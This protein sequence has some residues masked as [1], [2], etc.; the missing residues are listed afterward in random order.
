MKLTVLIAGIAGACLLAGP[1][2]KAQSQPGSCLLLNNGAP[3]I[4]SGV[5]TG[6]SYNTAGLSARSNWSQ[7]ANMYGGLNSNWS[8][9]KAV[10]RSEPCT[11]TKKGFSYVYTCRAIGQPCK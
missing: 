5:G 11:S 8:W 1:A 7:Q 4:I 2:A 9:F 3:R 6:S 10:N